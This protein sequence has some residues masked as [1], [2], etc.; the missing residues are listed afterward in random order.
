MPAVGADGRGQGGRNDGKDN[1]WLLGW[2]GGRLGASLAALVE[3]KPRMR[4]L[5]PPQGDM[6]RKL[7]S[8]AEA[9]PRIHS[10]TSRERPTRHHRRRGGS[11]G[12]ANPLEATLHP[13]T[14]TAKS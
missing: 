6:L 2:G 7:L 3:K 12:L 4:S 11:W 1:G 13:L 9:P 5:K 8:R 10:Q 14:K